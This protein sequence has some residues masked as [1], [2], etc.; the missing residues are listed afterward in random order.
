VRVV[1]KPQINTA[2]A[3]HV[4]IAADDRLFHLARETLS[5]CLRN[6]CANLKESKSD[7]LHGTPFLTNVNHSIM[8]R[9]WGLV[10]N[11]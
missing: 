10:V 2:I 9:V 8:A 1:T 7:Y 5:V 11:T 4:M 3:E 6:N